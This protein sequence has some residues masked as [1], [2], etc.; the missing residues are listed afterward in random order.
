MY[1]FFM[2]L[3]GLRVKLINHRM[4]Q[5]ERGDMVEKAHEAILQSE[6]LKLQWQACFSSE[7][8]LD[9][10]VFINLQY[11]YVT[12][13]HLHDKMWIN[14]TKNHYYNIEKCFVHVITVMIT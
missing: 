14:I 7:D 5:R 10:K 13:Y 3:E 6:D 11:S 8:L 12:G 2:S 9:K 1:T 4:L